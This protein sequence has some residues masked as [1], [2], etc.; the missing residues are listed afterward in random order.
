MLKN[1]HMTK[2][3]RN[4]NVSIFTCLQVEI[5]MEIGVNKKEKLKF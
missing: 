1:R 4:V 2:Q 3:L 5:E